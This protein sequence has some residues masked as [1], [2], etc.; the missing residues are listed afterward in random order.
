MYGAQQIEL[1]HKEHEMMQYN[2]YEKKILDIHKIACK[3]NIFKDLY[4]KHKHCK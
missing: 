1:R 2:W 3:Y 4:K